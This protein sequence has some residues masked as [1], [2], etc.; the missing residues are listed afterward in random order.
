MQ[1]CI[2]I[3]GLL[4]MG[5]CGSA[6]YRGYRLR[7]ETATAFQTK[8]M[9][10]RAES[11]RGI[12][13]IRQAK[14]FHSAWLP[15]THF[16][17]AFILP[18]RHNTWV[19]ICRQ[20]PFKSSPKLTKITSSSKCLAGLH[21]SSLV[22]SQRSPLPRIACMSTNKSL[23]VFTSP[24][25]DTRTSRNRPSTSPSDSTRQRTTHTP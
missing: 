14:A 23:H 22:L 24:T 2:I 25:S 12:L 8:N 17:P 9:S 11:W 6:G 18:S 21:I 10:L 13:R 3:L 15:S 16:H 7:E 19:V 20:H 4:L 1:L 5:R